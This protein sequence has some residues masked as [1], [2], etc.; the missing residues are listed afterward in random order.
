MEVAVRDG[1]FAQAGYDNGLQALRAL[2]VSTVEVAI[3][4]GPPF[5]R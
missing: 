2:D 1:S 4:R 5:A 3:N